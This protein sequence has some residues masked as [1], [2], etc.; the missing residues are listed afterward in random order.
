MSLTTVCL[1]TDIK[2][3]SNKRL[4]TLHT[5]L[6][7]IADQAVLKEPIGVSRVAKGLNPVASLHKSCINRNCCLM[8]I[9]TY[10]CVVMCIYAHPTATEQQ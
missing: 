9:A 7:A 5:Y 3:I 8:T 1:Q 10:L 2:Y 6:L 4:H